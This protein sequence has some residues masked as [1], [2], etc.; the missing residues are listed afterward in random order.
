MSSKPARTLWIAA[1]VFSGVP[2][3]AP[4]LAQTPPPAAT[5]PDPILPGAVAG[6]KFSV[7]GFIRTDML[8]T[9][10]TDGE[11][12]DGNAAR[13][14]YLPG[15]TPVE[16]V[17]EGTDL[18]AHIKFSRIWFGLDH[19]DDPKTKVTARIEIDFFG[20]SL[21]TEQST[22]TYGAT[23]R[24]AYVS[25]R[26]WLVGQTWSNFMDPA[27]MP[28]SV[29]FVGPTE[30]TVFVRQPQV[31]YTRGGFSVSLE[32]PETSITPYGGG[33]RILSDDNSV[34]DVVGRYVHK[35][36][37]GHVG[38]AVMV[39]ELAYEKTGTGATDDSTFAAAATFGGK[40]NF[41]KGH[42][43][44]FL[45]NAGDA[46]GRYTGLGVASDASLDGSGQ[47]EAIGNV[48]GFVAFRF[49]FSPKWR[50][51][52][53]YSLTSFDNDPALTGVKVTESTN[54]VAVNLFCTPVPK[55]DVGTELRFATRK[56]E[57]GSEGDL[58]RL[59]FIVRYM[60]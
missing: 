50:S 20:G 26:G 3:L 33:D 18:D 54:S 44:R 32:N 2:A 36:K 43:L 40:F 10:T 41:G 13:D 8:F 59:H 17:S 58:R 1:L 52:V 29:D 47:I 53:Y 56:I 14:V 34:P 27:L 16:G 45:V 42:D 51:N 46:L 4:A 15:S 31:R 49:V 24:H 23:I 39:R 60:F 25:W 48:S 22:H 37:W 7:G 5:Q 9:D 55:I 12:A 6:T 21:G 35:G 57:N 38:G 19:G 30:G 28:D 11:I